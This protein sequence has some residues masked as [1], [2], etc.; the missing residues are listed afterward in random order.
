HAV[1]LISKTT[2]YDST[3]AGAFLLTQRLPAHWR[4][5]YD[6]DSV[7]I[8]ENPRA[9]PR[10]WIVPQA[11]VVT[12]EEALRAIRGESD[13][14]FN[15][16]EL[17]LLEKPDEKI[18][19]G[20]PQNKFS[21]VAEAKVVGYEPNRLVIETNADKSGVLVVS[22]M[23]HPGWQATVDGQP[24]RIF[25]A[26]YLLRGVIVPEGKHRVEMVYRPATVQVGGLVSLAAFALLIGL[27]IKTKSNR[28]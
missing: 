7:Q 10:A 20:F 23:N 1:L 12:E 17:A 28:R 21:N 6:F 18:K 4:K 3:A 9:L 27:A 8:Y 5:V 14:P 2:A 13:Q 19:L 22:E 16:R 26:D 25:T 15:P 24:Y 11:K